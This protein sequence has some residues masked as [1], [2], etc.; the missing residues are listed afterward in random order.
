MQGHSVKESAHPFLT[1]PYL[2]FGLLLLAIGW[3][4]LISRLLAG[5]WAALWVAC[6]YLSSAAIGQ[7]SRLVNVG[8]ASLRIFDLS[9]EW[10]VGGVEAKV[11]AYALV[12]LAIA[13]E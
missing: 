11:F 12:F 7:A 2:V 6:V 4:A 3:C 1:K 10:I 5:R 13:L 8:E 9:G